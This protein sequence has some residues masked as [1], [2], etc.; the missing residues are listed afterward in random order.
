MHALDTDHP[1]LGLWL[2]IGSILA[3][4]GMA[5]CVKLAAADIPTG[6]IVFYRSFFA[7]IPLVGFLWLR[8]EF[9]AGLRTR[10]P[11]G[12]LLRCL[13][14][15]AAMFAAFAAL[16]YLPLADYTLIG[17]LAPFATAVLARLLLGECAEPRIWVG[18]GLGFAGVIALVWPELHIDQPREGYLL[19]VTLGLAT[20]VLTAVAK[21]QIRS[22]SRTES[23]GAIAFYFALTCTLAGAATA[24]FAWAP[25]DRAQLGLLIGAG[26]LG[27]VAHILMT[28]GIQFCPLTRQAGLDYLALVF[29]VALDAAALAIFPGAW[30]LA[31]MILVLSAAF[32]SFRTKH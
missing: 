17:F 27:G 2:R 23:A 14:G 16:R 6:Q 29:A 15:C 31:A 25:V 30:T 10:R 24:G 28:L 1:T 8:D 32:L 13:A 11:F 12:H 5:L 7:M 21:V 4:S 3:F 20:A 19:G 26:L 22:L 18:L 9:P